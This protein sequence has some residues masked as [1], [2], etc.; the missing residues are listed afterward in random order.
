M[1]M[2][3]RQ[4]DRTGEREG[5]RGS[6]ANLSTNKR[7]LNLMFDLSVSTARWPVLKEIKW[8]LNVT[9]YSFAKDFAYFSR[10]EAVVRMSHDIE[11]LRK[12]SLNQ[13]I[14]V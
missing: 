9:C 6:V 11:R 3:G 8:F 4:W 10:A 13:V 12:T 2:R 14:V 5:W 7:H 1:R